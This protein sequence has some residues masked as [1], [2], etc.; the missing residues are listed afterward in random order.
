MHVGADQEGPR[1]TAHGDPRI[2]PFGR[3]LRRFKL[4]EFPQLLNVLI[5]QMT[6]VGPRPEDPAFLVHYSPEQRQ[7]LEVRPGI[8][9]PASLEY[10]HEEGLLTG[11]DWETVY[12]DKILPGKL[13]LELEYIPVQTFRSDLAVIWRTFLALFR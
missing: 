1:I 4:D 11:P 7:V 13:R 9:S 6:L 2:T 12:L 5:G 8:T 3:W 10:R